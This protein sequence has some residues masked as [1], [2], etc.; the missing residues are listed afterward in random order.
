MKKYFKIFI[1]VFLTS[2]IISSCSKEESKSSITNSEEKI[3]KRY[4]SCP[5]YLDVVGCESPPQGFN[6]GATLLYEGCS[7]PFQVTGVACSWGIYFN[8]PIIDWSLLENA[9]SGPLSKCQGFA[10]H[11]LSLYDQGNDL[12]L[13][14]VLLDI[15]KQMSLFAQN[16]TIE[17]NSQINPLFYPCN[18]NITP[19]TYSIVTQESECTMFCVKSI[20][21]QGLIISEILCGRGCC[22]RS[23]PFCVN[24]PDDIIY[25]VP[26]YSDQLP[27]TIDNTIPGPYSENCPSGSLP[28]EICNAACSKI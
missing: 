21:G 22:T 28:L 13:N 12:E 19:P 7:I 4:S 9:A 10:N 2:I 18:G 23:T 24:G 16:G 27:C 11:L 8:P 5:N 25:G 20:V 3:D 17:F 1:I 6:I 14:E 15:K 26:E